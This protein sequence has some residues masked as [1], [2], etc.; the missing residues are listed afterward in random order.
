MGFILLSRLLYPV[1]P[2]DCRMTKSTGNLIFLAAGSPRIK[3][4]N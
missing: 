3:W 4:T 1:H 2:Q